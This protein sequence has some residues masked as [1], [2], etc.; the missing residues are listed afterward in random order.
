MRVMES[1]FSDASAVERLSHT[2][3]PI[4]GT[5]ST[6]VTCQPDLMKTIAMHNVSSVIGLMKETSTTTGNG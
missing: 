1:C 5:T 4:V 2:M 6:E 3:R